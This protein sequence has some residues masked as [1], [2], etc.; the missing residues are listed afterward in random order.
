MLQLALNL[1]NELFATAVNLVLRFKEGPAFGVALGLER[2]DLF[3]TRQLILQGQGSLGRATSLLDLAVQVFNLA[4]Q[5][6]LQIIRPAAQLIGF[7]L[8]EGGIALG[9]SPPDRL[10]TPAENLLQDGLFDLVPDVP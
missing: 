5:A 3:L 6:D 4:F 9:D 2:F 10:L 8:E 1:R 7:G